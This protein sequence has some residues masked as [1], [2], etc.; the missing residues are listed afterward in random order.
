MSGDTAQV[1]VP[2]SAGSSLAGTTIRTIELVRGSEGWSATGFVGL[3]D[4]SAFVDAMA[5][6]DLPPDP[7][8]PQCVDMCLEAFDGDADGD[9]DMADFK[10][11]QSVFTGE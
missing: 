1:S 11:F 7:T 6:P 2:L 9:L 10:A 4:Y 3:I 5:G 8:S